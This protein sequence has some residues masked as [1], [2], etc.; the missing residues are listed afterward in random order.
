MINRR[1]KTVGLG[2]ANCHTFRATGITAYLL[3]GGTLERAQNCTNRRTAPHRRSCFR[4][5]VVL[6]FICLDN[7]GGSQ[8]NKRVPARPSRIRCQAAT[9]SWTKARQWETERTLF[10]SARATMCPPAKVN[11]VWP[12]NDA[13]LHTS[14]E[15][16]RRQAPRNGA[17][18]LDAARELGIRDAQVPRRR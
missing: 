11:G 6:G 7:H 8:Q 2:E 4:L 3:N 14:L 1:V 16:A 5:P 13:W 17:S 12:F 9:G 10:S 15:E 18:I